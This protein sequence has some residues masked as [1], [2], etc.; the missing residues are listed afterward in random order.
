MLERAVKVQIG[1][2][3]AS[4]LLLSRK[5][6]VL[7]LVWVIALSIGFYAVKGGLFTILT[8]GQYPRLGTGDSFIAG[9]Q[10]LRACD[11]NVDSAVGLSLRTV[12]LAPTG[13]GSASSVAIACLPISALGSQ[14]RGAVVAIVAMASFLWFKSRHEAGLRRSGAH[15][16]RC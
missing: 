15:R 7:A 10:R 6:H 1:T 9:Q 3:L 8:L 2:I 13:C 14:S 12:P 11:G 4:R 16:G 5:E